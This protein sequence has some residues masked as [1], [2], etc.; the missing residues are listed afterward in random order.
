VNI[1]RRA[2]PPDDPSRFVRNRHGADHV[3]AI[4]PVP[5]AQPDFALENLTLLDGGIPHFE[6]PLHVVRVYRRAP[7]QRKRRLRR[8]PRVLVPPAVEVIDGAVRPG[9]P[10]DVGYGVSKLASLVLA[11]ERFVGRTAV[12]LSRAQRSIA[13]R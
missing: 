9:R 3:P 10:Y 4:G 1:G 6:E 7:A 5:I 12:V 2:A 13:E 11:L 8:H